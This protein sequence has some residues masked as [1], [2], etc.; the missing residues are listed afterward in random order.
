MTVSENC[1]KD[2]TIASFP[3]GEDD[4]PESTAA[5]T[6]DDIIKRTHWQCMNCQAP[7][8]GHYNGVFEHESHC[9]FKIIEDTQTETLEEATMG[10]ME[11]D[12]ID[13]PK[14]YKGDNPSKVSTDY[15]ENDN[16][17]GSI[18]MKNEADESYSDEEVDEDED[19]HCDDIVEED[20]ENGSYFEEEHHNK[21]GSVQEEEQYGT[22]ESFLE[23]ELDEETDEDE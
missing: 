1:P 5:T 12:S 9:Q 16:S 6:W 7:I 15:K 17:D 3:S 10:T 8:G 4:R 19:L 20:S 14:L 23:E 18:D 2:S 13:Q 11:V 21:D 22:D